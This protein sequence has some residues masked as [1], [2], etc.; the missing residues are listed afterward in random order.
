MT[1][2]DPTDIHRF[3]D[4]FYLFLRSSGID[5]VKTDAQ[6]FLDLLSSPHDRRDLIAPYQDAWL[7]A[8]LRHFSIKAISCMSQTPQIIF[9]SQL[10]TN[11]PRFMVRNSDDFF[12]EIPSSHPWHLFT[13]AHNAL[14]TSHLNILPDW[15]M[16]QTSHPYSAFHA[17]GRCISGGP[18]YF[19]DEPGKHDIALIAQMTAPTT[20]GKTAI[21]RPP[22]IGKSIN[23]YTA[24]EEAR[25]LK[26]SSYT[27]SASTGTGL[28]AAF[29]VSPRPVSEF[30]NLADFP[31]VE[32]DTDYVIRAHTSGQLSPPMSLDHASAVVSL[33]LDVKC[34]EILSSYPLRAFT[35]AGSSGLRSSRT[36]VAVLGLLAKMTGAAAVVGTPEMII[37]ENGRLRIRVSLKALGVLGIY[38]S[39]LANR[40]VER[41]VMV[42]MQGRGLPVKTMRKGEEG[43]V[44]EVD[45]ERAWAEMGLEAGWGNEVGVEV[46]VR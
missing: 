19:T 44:L 24:Y 33:D 31:G 42:L 32:P 27:G 5:S 7:I 4:D 36:N 37:Q 30:I 9:H 10:P 40:E 46:F 35:L 20:R 29:N 3:Y 28:L 14:L 34:Y 12:P 11:K 17:A 21:L 22:V 41:D 15:D 25:F 18:I 16:F 39:T 13:N 1:V 6:F 23:I 45:V 8:S 2:I 43:S 38:I 26:V